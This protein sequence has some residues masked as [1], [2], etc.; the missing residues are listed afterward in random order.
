MKYVLIKTLKCEL[1]TIVKLHI[2]LYYFLVFAS[3]VVGDNSIS[4]EVNI[5][6]HK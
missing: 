3:S 4:L 1:I 6:T 2:N 5:N